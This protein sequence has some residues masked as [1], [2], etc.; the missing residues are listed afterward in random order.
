VLGDLR[1][2]VAGPPQAINAGH[3]SRDSGELGVTRH[4]TTYAMS[5]G[6]TPSPLDR[7]LALFTV[8]VHLN[9]DAIYRCSGLLLEI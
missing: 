6:H 7:H 4:W 3:K 2:A 8:L 9:G 1:N 5:A